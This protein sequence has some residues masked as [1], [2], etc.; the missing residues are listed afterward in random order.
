MLAHKHIIV[1]LVIGTGTVFVLWLLLGGR[2]FCSW[3]C[4]Y[5]WSRNGRRRST[6]GWS[7]RSW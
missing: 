5:H 7:R 1:N 2:T 4:P 3:V 6:S